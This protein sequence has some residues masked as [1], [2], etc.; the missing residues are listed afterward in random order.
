MKKFLPIIG[1]Q[2]FLYLLQ[3]VLFPNLFD[4]YFPSSNE[5]TWFLI[6]TTAIASIVGM[7]S[8]S[9]NLLHWVLSDVL[10]TILIFIYAPEGA[11]GIGMRGLFEAAHYDP[12]S[13]WSGVI[14]LV[15]S[16][17]FIQFLSWSGIKI[18]KYV[19]NMRK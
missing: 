15:I 9:Q 11:Y 19:L 8:F 2:V 16:V 14:I 18:S 1:V 6:I 5:S 4:K 17:F 7:L 13:K 12:K 3:F 10:Y